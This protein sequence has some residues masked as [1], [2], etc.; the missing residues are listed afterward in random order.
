MKYDSAS[1]NLLLVS[2]KIYR[3]KD[4]AAAKMQLSNVLRLL[5]RAAANCQGCDE[6]DLDEYDD[7][8]H[9]VDVNEEE[10]ESKTGSCNGTEISPPTN[11]SC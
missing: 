11:P 4:Y 3:G 6:Y 5:P 9:A 10:I 2:L 8:D 1:L 7:N